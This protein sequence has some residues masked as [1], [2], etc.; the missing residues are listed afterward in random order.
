MIKLCY[1]NNW[2]AFL[3]WPY[4]AEAS[5]TYVFTCLCVSVSMFAYTVTLA[6]DSSNLFRSLACCLSFCLREDAVLIRAV[7]KVVQ[8]FLLVVYTVGLSVD[9][10]YSKNLI[11]LKA[12]SS[13]KFCHYLTH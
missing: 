7:S 12:L 10:G 1:S 4:S 11:S 9:F 2:D 6:L 8:A 3:F 13:V 5:N